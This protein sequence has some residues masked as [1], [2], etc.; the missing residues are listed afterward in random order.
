MD[1]QRASI[2]IKHLEENG[3]MCKRSTI[4]TYDSE[5]FKEFI[6]SMIKYRYIKGVSETYSTR[7]NHGEIETIVI[8]GV[9]DLGRAL[10]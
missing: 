7:E 9:T 2:I 6:A 3:A 4:P 10:L 8:T 5:D 1:T